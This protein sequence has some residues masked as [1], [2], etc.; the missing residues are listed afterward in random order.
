LH[1][2]YG[3]EEYFIPEGQGR[4]FSFWNKEAAARVA[5]DENCNA[6][7]KQIYIDGEPWP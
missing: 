2:V 3:I 5:V 4:N 6:A 7:L 1:I